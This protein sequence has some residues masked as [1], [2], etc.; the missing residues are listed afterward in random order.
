[1]RIRICTA[2]LALLLAA[3]ALLSGCAGRK[4]GKR[5]VC[6]AAVAPNDGIVM[7]EG[8]VR[9]DTGMLVVQNQ[10]AV[11]VTAYLYDTA[12]EDGDAPAFTLALP[13]GGVCTQY[14]VPGGVEYAVGLSAFVTVRQEI[15]V[16]VSDSA[17]LEPFAAS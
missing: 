6:A 8:R 12:A 17:V 16:L 3:L 5:W 10:T 9:T 7:C 14:Q 1:M 4:P 13:A 11:R 15:A 2:A